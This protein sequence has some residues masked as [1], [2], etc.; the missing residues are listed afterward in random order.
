L[1]EI[2]GP[3]SLELMP[4]KDNRITP[5]DLKTIVAFLDGKIGNPP[6]QILCEICGHQHWAVGEKLV[7]VRSYEMEVE[8][9]PREFLV[10]PLIPF[11]CKNCSN[12]KFLNAYAVGVLSPSD[13][14]K[15]KQRGE[16][17]RNAT[18]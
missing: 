4:D 9:N 14:V 2:D 8:P 17:A 7:R 6:K 12:T 5:D 16:E 11:I 13:A 18:A 3:A 10:Y 15:A 1:K